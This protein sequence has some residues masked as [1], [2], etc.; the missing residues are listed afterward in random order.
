MKIGAQMY[1]VRELCRTLDGLDETMKK[2]ADIGYTTIQLSGVCS[3][4][5]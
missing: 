2:V 5:N 4:F 3:Q 1:T